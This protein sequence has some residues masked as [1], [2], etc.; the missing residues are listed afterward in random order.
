[1]TSRTLDSVILIITVPLMTR[2]YSLLPALAAALKDPPHHTRHDEA[3]SRGKTYKRDECRILLCWGRASINW[4]CTQSI[5]T[6]LLGADQQLCS[7][8]QP[9]R[10][11]CEPPDAVDFDSFHSFHPYHIFGFELSIYIPHVFCQVFKIFLCS[12]LEYSWHQLDPGHHY[13]FICPD[14]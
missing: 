8:R 10:I 5:A 3:T 7:L 9:Y 4:S 1:M 11:H 13:N 14:A 2:V 6:G 12:N